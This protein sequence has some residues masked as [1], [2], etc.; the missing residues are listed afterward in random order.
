ME[1]DAAKDAPR[2]ISE[3]HLTIFSRDFAPISVS[4]MSEIMADHEPQLP[5]IPVDIALMSLWIVLWD[6]PLGAISRQASAEQSVLLNS[7]AIA[8]SR[9]TKITPLLT[10]FQPITQHTRVM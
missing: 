2:L 9:G 4:T 6:Q 5:S 3:G 7:S 1:N 8:R 10:H